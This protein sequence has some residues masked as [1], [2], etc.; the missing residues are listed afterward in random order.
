MHADEFELGMD[1]M[2]GITRAPDFPTDEE[3]LK[4]RFDAAPWFPLYLR[5][6]TRQRILAARV[7]RA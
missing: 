6:P 4:T 2:L 7:A 1:L 5:A 3:S